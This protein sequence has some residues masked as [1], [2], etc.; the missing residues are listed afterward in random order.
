LR[1]RLPSWFK[2]KI[3][4]S[5]IIK[6][7]QD[8]LDGLHLHTICE[9]ALCP[10]RGDCL[11]KGTATFLILGNICTRN[12]TFC[13][14]QKGTPDPVDADESSRLADAVVRMG[15]NYAVI[16]SVTRDD[17]SDG[18]SDHFAKCVT[19]IRER[20]KAIKVE[21]LI[22]D[23]QGSLQNL[24]IILQSHPDVINH[25]IETV[26]RLYAAVRPMADFKESLQLL[27]RSKDLAPAIAAKSGIM[28]GLGETKQEL[29]AAMEELKD[30]GCDI[31]T[32]GQ[33]LQPSL[34]HHPVV[35]FIPPAAFEEYAHAAK[36]MGF[37]AVASAPL[38]RSSFNA[39]ALYELAQRSLPK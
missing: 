24:Q 39:V 26:P 13:A 14:V 22:P 10:N 9:S 12:C 27:R 1:K 5:G 2:K 29:L 36:A 38:V 30:A 32:I 37:A 25:N 3:H 31:L 20:N 28:V 19:A 35:Q 21:L 4:S 18:G 16:T 33:Y 11:S 6:E 17:L 34:H 7:T 23:F 8:L 15:L